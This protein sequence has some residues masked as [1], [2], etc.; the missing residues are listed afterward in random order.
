MKKLMFLFLLLIGFVFVS[1]TAECRGRKK[2]NGGRRGMNRNQNT[3]PSIQNTFGDKSRQGYG[4][5]KQGN[6]KQRMKRFDA[7]GDGQSNADELRAGTD[8]LDPAS[9]LAVS[10]LQAG[11]GHMAFKWASV[12]GKRY[13]IK[14]ATSV[15]GEFESLVSGILAT[16]AETTVVLVD[17]ASSAFYKVVAE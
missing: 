14:R 1:D 17:G 16:G 2:R 9:V 10:A 11:N 4:E 7:D 5:F 12:E 15:G 3:D 13:T 6:S 8:P